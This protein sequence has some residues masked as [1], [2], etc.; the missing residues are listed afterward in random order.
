MPSDR[1][2][3]SL[4]KVLCATKPHGRFLEFGSTC[5]GLCAPM[6]A[7]FSFVTVLT[8][9]VCP[10]WDAIATYLSTNAIPW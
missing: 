10:L 4:L 6:I 7:K 5:A 2:T 1:E 8:E 3:G 9:W